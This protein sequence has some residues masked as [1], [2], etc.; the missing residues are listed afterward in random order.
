MGTGNMRKPK[1]VTCKV[2]YDAII[3]KATVYL[4]VWLH[5]VQPETTVYL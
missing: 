2:T 1:S 4:F 3:Q 5:S